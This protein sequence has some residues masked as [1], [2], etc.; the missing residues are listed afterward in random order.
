MDAAQRLYE[1][2]GFTRIP[3]ALGATGH[4]G[5]NRFYLRAL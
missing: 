4:F 1:R 3:A 2:N 5:C